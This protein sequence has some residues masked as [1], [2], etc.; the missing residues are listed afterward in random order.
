LGW[1]EKDGSE[2]EKEGKRIKED[3][4]Q[5]EKACGGYLE[6]KSG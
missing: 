1:T 3:R 6:V 4:L 5:S 2:V